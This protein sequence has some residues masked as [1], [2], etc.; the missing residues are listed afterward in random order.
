MVWALVCFLPFGL[1]LGLAGCG[2]VPVSE[3]GL[4][5]KPN[6]QFSDSATFAYTSRLSPQT[7]PGSAFSG[8][9]QNA[10]CTSCK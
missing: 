8:G 2:H 7:E 9:A 4:V 6:M 1:A 3:Q 5:A 10:G